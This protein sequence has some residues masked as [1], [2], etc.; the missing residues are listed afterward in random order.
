MAALNSKA[1]LLDIEGTCCPVRNC[2]PKGLPL[3]LPIGSD[4]RS[5]EERLILT[6]KQY[7]HTQLSYVQDTLFPYALQNLRSFFTTRLEQREVSPDLFAA[8][9]VRVRRLVHLHKQF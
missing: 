5:I 2:S 6:Q 8:A 9:K 3:P 1:V 7:A 4:N